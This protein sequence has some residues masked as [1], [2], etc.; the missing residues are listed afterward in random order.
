MFSG[1][2]FDFRFYPFNNEIEV[3]AQKR[4]SCATNSKVF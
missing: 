2:F 1:I 4:I 3:S